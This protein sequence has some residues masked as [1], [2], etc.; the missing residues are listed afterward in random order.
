MFPTED[1]IS[2]IRPGP[3][4]A[5]K[6]ASTEVIIMGTCQEGG[7]SENPEAGGQS[8]ISFPKEVVY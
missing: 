4:I 8:M 3:L 2:V 7:H 5:K 6:L 1:M